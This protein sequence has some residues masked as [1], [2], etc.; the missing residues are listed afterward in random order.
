MMQVPISPY[1]CEF[2]GGF[3]HSWERCVKFIKGETNE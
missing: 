3:W 2:C 1:K